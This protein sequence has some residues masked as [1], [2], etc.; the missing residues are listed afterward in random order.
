MNLY[1]MY[2]PAFYW[3]CSKVHHLQFVLLVSLF[4]VLSFLL[5]VKYTRRDWS[6]WYKLYLPLTLKNCGVRLLTIHYYHHSRRIYTCARYFCRQLT[7]IYVIYRAGG[8][9]GK[10]L[11][12][13]PRAQFFSHTDRPRPVNNLFIFFY[14]FAFF[15]NSADKNPDR[16]VSQKAGPVTSARL[17]NQIRGFGIPAR[18]DAFGKNNQLYPWDFAEQ[19]LPKDCWKTYNRMFFQVFWSYYDRHYSINAAQFAHCYHWL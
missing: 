11:C 3:T 18:W 2:W 8:P 1:A 14:L 19:T 17:A 7:Y 10:K 4:I 16:S 15:A 13:R 9:Y 5:I 6:A 12:S